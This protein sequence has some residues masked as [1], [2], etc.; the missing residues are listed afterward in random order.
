MTED[1]KPSAV[2]VLLTLAPI[3]P[4]GI[5]WTLTEGFNKNPSRP[6]FFSKILPLA[7]VLI[8]IIISLIAFNLARDEELEST[9]EFKYRLIFKF[10]EGSAIVYVIISI[11]FSLMIVVTY[12]V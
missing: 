10:I 2:L 11:V 8:T 9:G 3:I 7:L 12:F 4:L 5:T 6:P 1:G